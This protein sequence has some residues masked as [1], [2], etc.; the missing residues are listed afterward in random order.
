MHA[1]PQLA[2][3][4]RAD[5]HLVDLQNLGAAGLMKLNHTRHSLTPVLLTLPEWIVHRPISEANAGEAAPSVGR[6]DASALDV[7]LGSITARRRF[8]TPTTIFVFI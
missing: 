1:Q 6:V 2:E 7:G 8:V 4:R 5:V 3:S